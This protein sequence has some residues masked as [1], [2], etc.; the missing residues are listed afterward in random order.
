MV[1]GGHPRYDQG[2]MNASTAP[3]VMTVLH[4]SLVEM[5]ALVR[6]DEP[7]AARH[8]VPAGAVEMVGPH[9]RHVRLWRTSLGTAYAEW[10]SSVPGSE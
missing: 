1:A 3:F 4:L 9:E 5:P 8:D 10:A 2:L 6:T 7:S